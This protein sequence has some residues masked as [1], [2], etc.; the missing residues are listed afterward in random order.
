M[1]FSAA[2]ILRVIVLVD[3]RI[4]SCCII[5]SVNRLVEA[6]GTATFADGWSVT[7]R[8]LLASDLLHL[9][10]VKLPRKL[11]LK[12]FNFWFANQRVRP[13]L[14]QHTH[15]LCFPNV[16]HALHA[17]ARPVQVNLLSGIPLRKL[18]LVEN[19][20]LRIVVHREL[21][22]EVPALTNRCTIPFFLVKRVIIIELLFFFLNGLLLLLGLCLLWFLLHYGGTHILWV[23]T[24][25]HVL[26][27][28]Q[29][30]CR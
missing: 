2:T 6:N 19:R 5:Y 10:L 14:V 16:K 3:S 4:S 15:N 22:D 8:L 23:I 13:Y 30:C 11:H 17:G 12:L 7:A 18:D 1:L 20:R 21:V 9:L 27:G 24:V 29:H 26:A 28:C 25:N